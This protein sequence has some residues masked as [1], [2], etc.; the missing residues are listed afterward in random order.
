MEIGVGVK[1]LAG[2]AE[3]DGVCAGGKVAESVV[4]QVCV[5]ASNYVADRAEVVGQGPEDFGGRGVCEEFVLLVRR[6]EVM[7]RDGSV[8]NLDGGLV[9]FRD[10]YGFGIADYLTD[11]DVVVIVGVFNDLNGFPSLVFCVKGLFCDC[12]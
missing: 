3:E 2:V 1:R 12:S 5:F 6:P 10:E 7:V 11:P 4:N 8:V 9:V